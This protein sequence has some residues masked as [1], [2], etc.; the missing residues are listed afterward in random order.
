MIS[1]AVATSASPA[2]AGAATLVRKQ[3]NRTIP[4]TKAR[5]G[6][7]SGSI[8]QFYQLRRAP[9]IRFT[10]ARKLVTAEGPR[11]F[12]ASLA[13]A[14]HRAVRAAIPDVLAPTAQYR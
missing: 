10:A 3:T 12:R 13:A 1:C 6:A 14:R 11:I 2:R 4:I 5:I 7:I 9:A 8:S